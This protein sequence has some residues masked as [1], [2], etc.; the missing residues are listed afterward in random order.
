MRIVVA[1]SVLLIVALAGGLLLLPRLVSW[2]DYREEVTERAEA[3][4]GQSVAIGGRIDLEL[5]PRPTLSLAQATLSGD[6]PAPDGHVLEVDRLDLRLKALPLLGGRFEVEEVRLVRPVLEVERV[7]QPADLGAALALAGSGFVLPLAAGGPSHLSVVDGRAVLNDG[8]VR[9]IEAINL[10]VAAAGPDGPYA[11][12]GDF[13]VSEQPFAFT[14]QLGQLAAESWSTL[15]LEVSA[16]VA[17]GEP[18]RLSFHGLTWSDPRAW[19]LRGNLALRG[20]DA[21][22]ALAALGGALYGE[23]PTL[24]PWLAARFRL[25]GRLEF[26]DREA[27]LGALRVALADTEATGSLR[28]G[29]GPKP[30]IDLQLDMPR[31]VAPEGWPQAGDGSGLAALA[32]LADHVAGRID[33]AVQTLAYRGGTIRRLRTSLA[34]SG[35]GQITVEQARAIFPGQTTVGFTGALAGPEQDAALEG[36]LTVVT[37]NL[38]ELLEWLG[39]E[40]GAIAEGRLRSLSLASQLALREDTLRFADAELRVDASRIAGSLALSLG[41]RLQVAG[42]LALDRLDLDAYWPDGEPGEL[43]QSALQAFASVDA[44]LE[45]RIERLTWQGLRLAEVTLDGRSV[46]GR[47]TLNELSLQEAA[48]SRVRLA[49]EVDLERARFDLRA[50]LA[51]AR[52]AQ[53]LRRLGLAPPLLLGR[54][55]SVK[56][57]GSARG[58]LDAFDLALELRSE[59]A[60]LEAAGTVDGADEKPR[61]DLAVNASHPD[62]PELLDLLGVPRAPGAG[63]AQPFSMTGRLSGDLSAQATVV[64]SARLGA[65]SLTGRVGWD[66]AAPR[67]RLSA[68]ISAGDP[69]LD[70]LAGLAALAGLRFDPSVLEGPRLGA[71]STQPL[72]LRWLGALDAELELSAK[73][74]IVGSG[75]EAA[76]R[77]EQGRLLVDRLAAALWQGRLEAQASL[78]VDRALPF[79][80]IALDLRAID[81]G[82]L[83]AWLDLPPVVVGPADLYV[84]ATTAGDSPYDLI[85]GLIGEIEVGLSDGRLIGEPLAALRLLTVP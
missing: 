47:L 53:L 9:Q 1:L 48:D 23:A 77:L 55:S 71:W 81:P 52:P 68:Q 4:T 28:L 30:M 69:D 84:E 74:G 26:S 8:V 31:L 73:G 61:Y 79:L 17:A 51:T 43:A 83:A 36:A 65:M 56:I 66:G 40:A 35:T 12:E 41:P 29:V 80:A 34:L 15:Q 24:P 45:A 14:A 67:P 13:S 33:L 22:A 44:A 54:L 72:G 21:R 59:G 25:E 64:G 39:L 70:A 62:Y 6:G 7:A 19:Q 5:L 18:T 76:L 49:G 57:D 85:R 37:G 58:D 63:A 16:P 60:Q 3:I 27:D 20:S 50:E 78:D 46:A 10:D 38:R 32:A 75:F 42:A 11:L 2:N 82:A